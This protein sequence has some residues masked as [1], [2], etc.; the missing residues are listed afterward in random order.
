MA[1]FGAGADVPAT[2]EPKAALRLCVAEYL[3]SAIVGSKL[4]R[5]F[6]KGLPTSPSVAAS[7]GMADRESVPAGAGIGVGWVVQ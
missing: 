5:A 1:E 3:F 4:G 7:L 6:F 2:A